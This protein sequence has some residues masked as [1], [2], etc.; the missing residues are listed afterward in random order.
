MGAWARL[1]MGHVGLGISG[2]TTS[3]SSGRG[4]PSGAPVSPRRSGAAGGV[5]DRPP[6]FGSKTG[7]ALLSSGAALSGGGD[8][9]VAPGRSMTA[10]SPAVPEVARQAARLWIGVGR[11][12]LVRQHR[13]RM[14]LHAQL[15]V[16]PAQQPLAG[17]LV[18]RVTPQARPA[19]HRAVRPGVLVHQLVVAVEA[20]RRIVPARTILRLVALL[21]LLPPRRAGGPRAW[22]RSA[23]RPAPRRRRARWG[24]ARRQRTGSASRS[25]PSSPCTR[26]T[27]PPPRSPP[28]P[29]PGS[30]AWRPREGE[31]AEPLGVGRTS[32]G[33][34]LRETTW[35]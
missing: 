21:A 15:P 10:E 16:R 1:G 4:G 35:E 18:R 33:Q 9:A 5:L 20:R 31:A 26:T 24:P 19:R 2:G 12:R 29:R 32:S 27:P 6:S 7:C 30:S 11:H 8:W 17:R 22:R 25:S 3:S 28:A 23:C 34:S 13:R 14:A